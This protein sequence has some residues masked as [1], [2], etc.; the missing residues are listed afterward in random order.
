[1][2]RNTP[3]SKLGVPD[4]GGEAASDS[5]P[6]V[7]AQLAKLP[8]IDLPDPFDVLENPRRWF[9]L[10]LEGNAPAALGVYNVLR[11]ARRFG[12]PIAD[13]DPGK[14][15]DVLGFISSNADCHSIPANF[16]DDE[17]RWLE[18]AAQA[19]DVNARLMYAMGA[20]VVF[21]DKRRPP[22]SAER[23]RQI[24]SNALRWLDEL[25]REGIGYAYTLLVSAHSDG[26]IADSDP[27]RALAYQEALAALSAEPSIAAHAAQRRGRLSDA[28]AAA[29]RA[30]AED[31][32]AE[33]RVPHTGARPAGAAG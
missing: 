9:T 7:R 21:W 12:P 1:M 17:L 30:L 24:R 27:V 25:R 26:G 3:T 20:A 10:A 6:A 31:L 32:I 4:L 8:A 29:A 2:A 23:G 13:L 33:C 5:M 11:N 28:N 22:P 14:I 16:S 15:P 19:G 18:P